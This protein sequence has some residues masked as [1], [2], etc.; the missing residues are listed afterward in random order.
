M[1][2]TVFRR[3]QASDNRQGGIISRVSGAASA[4]C[5]R[6]L[7]VTRASPTEY[8]LPASVFG[9]SPPRVRAY[10][11]C[12]G[13]RMGRRS[14]ELALDQDVGRHLLDP[15]VGV[16]IDCSIRCVFRATTSTLASTE[17]LRRFG[18]PLI[19]RRPAVQSRAQT[20]MP[21]RSPWID[22]GASIQRTAR[23]LAHHVQPSGGIVVA[24]CQVEFAEQAGGFLSLGSA[25]PR[26]ISHR[27]IG[28]YRR[29]PSSCCDRTE[30]RLPVV[31]A[32]S[33]SRAFASFKSGASKPSVNQL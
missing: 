23:V 25:A 1:V 12:P 20:N 8:I 11:R 27:E 19:A 7:G 2:Q 10:I 15:E 31:H 14:W 16:A 3:R 6:G 32:S 24:Q 29:G 18:G 17:A 22:G 21:P 5:G 28:P 26:G 9:G 4:G 30:L 33:S 13:S